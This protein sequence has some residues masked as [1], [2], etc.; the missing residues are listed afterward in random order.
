MAT[1]HDDWTVE[2]IGSDEQITLELRDGEPRDMRV[3]RDGD[4]VEMRVDD[5]IGRVDGEAPEWL[6]NVAE[7]MGLYEVR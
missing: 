2:Q 3:T 7:R 5:G 6:E 4:T 1:S